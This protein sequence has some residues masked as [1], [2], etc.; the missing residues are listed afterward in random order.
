[1]KKL[2]IFILVVTFAFT[3]CSSTTKVETQTT[4]QE[5][6]TLENE[7]DIDVFISRFNTNL[8]SLDYE[9]IESASVNNEED[10]ILY[11]Y[12]LCGAESS[13]GI[14]VTTK[15]NYITSIDCDLVD[16]EM[17]YTCVLHILS[18]LEERIN[19]KDILEK[20]KIEKDG[21]IL[22]LEETIYFDDE[23]ATYTFTNIIGVSKALIITV[24]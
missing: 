22:D 18:A 8:D 17:S 15:D 13:I 11:R 7:I 3:G 21:T 16:E 4:I 5:V 19:A 23:V 24:K 12:L 6:Q 1:M 14:S 9:L 2:L 10:E 20:L